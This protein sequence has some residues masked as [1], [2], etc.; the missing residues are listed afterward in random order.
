[1]MIAADK[2]FVKISTPGLPNKPLKPLSSHQERCQMVTM[3]SIDISLIGFTSPSQTAYEHTCPN[4]GLKWLQV[5]SQGC[6]PFHISVRPFNPSGVIPPPPFFQTL[7]VVTGRKGDLHW[8]AQSEAFLALFN[9]RTTPN[10][11]PGFFLVYASS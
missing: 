10:I 1:M 6:E 9:S 3:A 8:L 2:I 7:L 11:K 4:V 5:I